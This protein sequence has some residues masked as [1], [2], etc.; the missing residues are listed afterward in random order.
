MIATQETIRVDCSPATAPTSSRAIAPTA[1]IISGSA[2]KMTGS[3]SS[4]IGRRPGPS[5]G[6]LAA[7][8]CPRLGWQHSPAGLH[9]RLR[10]GSAAE[11]RRDK[12][13]STRPAPARSEEHTS[14]LQSLRHLVCSL[15]LE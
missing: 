12:P 6:S 10:L 3:E 1:R 8:Q 14:E 9:G 7:H 11:T 15:L 4:G 2:G 13:P 5:G